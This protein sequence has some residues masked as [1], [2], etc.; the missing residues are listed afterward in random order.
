MDLEEKYQH[1]IDPWCA[2][3]LRYDVYNILTALGY[4]WEIDDLFY[5]YKREVLMIVE[6]V[7]KHPELLSDSGLL[8]EVVKKFIEHFTC[9]DQNLVYCVGI[10]KEL[11][12]SIGSIPV[13]TVEGLNLDLSAKPRAV[14]ITV[15]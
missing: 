3:F 2:V 6:S 12:S 10:A 9:E 13:K 1:L 5:H 11:I 7:D 14:L 15:D 4:G 8:G